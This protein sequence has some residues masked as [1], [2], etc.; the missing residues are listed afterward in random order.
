MQVSHLVSYKT[1]STETDKPGEISECF[2][3]YFERIGKSIAEKAKLVNKTLF[4]TFLSNS[5]SQSI[6]LEPPQSIEMYNLMNL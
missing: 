6:V 1:D 4:K 5:I 3:E 2:N